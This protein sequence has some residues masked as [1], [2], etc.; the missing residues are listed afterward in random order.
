MGWAMD[1][2]DLK[3]QLEQMARQLIRISPL[4]HQ[5]YQDQVE[6]VAMM[7]AQNLFKFDAGQHQ[8]RLCN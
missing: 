7:N 2:D 5:L 8:I 4:L 6:L 3:P 1:R